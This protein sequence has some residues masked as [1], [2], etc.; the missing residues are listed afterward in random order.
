VKGGEVF[1]NAKIQESQSGKCTS[2]NLFIAMCNVKNRLLN[3]VVE[4]KIRLAVPVIHLFQLTKG[5]IPQAHDRIKAG[6]GCGYSLKNFPPCDLGH[7]KA[8]WARS[9]Q[10]ERHHGKP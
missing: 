6:K 1:K 8:S 10:L 3:K 5:Y 9:I 4:D 2:Q 7:T